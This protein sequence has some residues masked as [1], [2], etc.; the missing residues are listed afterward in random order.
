[1]NQ[2]PIYMSGTDTF[3]GKICNQWLGGRLLDQL[4]DAPGF[5]DVTL[6]AKSILVSSGVSPIN[7]RNTTDQ[8]LL[9]QRFLIDIKLDSDH[10][11]LP[12]VHHIQ[13]RQNI[14]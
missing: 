3:W 11:V 5:S 2:Q 7:I 12:G 6:S 1:M 13:Y 8:L 10:F 4:D 14:F 9:E